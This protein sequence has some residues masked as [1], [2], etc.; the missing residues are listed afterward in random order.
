MDAPEIVLPLKINRSFVKEHN[1]WNFLYGWDFLGRGA[2]GQA[3]SFH[4]EYNAFPVPTMYKYCS[5]SVYWQDIEEGKKAI[6]DALKLVPSDKP[7][8]P[9]R[10]MGL[11]CSRLRELN[12]RLYDYMMAEI[13]NMAYPNIRIEI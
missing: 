11:G 7:I 12:Y 6:S 5:N 3:Y 8:I 10:K 13:K 4:G 1:E 9:C 2:L